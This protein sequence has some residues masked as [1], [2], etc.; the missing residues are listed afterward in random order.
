MYEAVTRGIRIRV[1]PQYLEDQSSPEESEFFWAYTIDIANESDETVQLLQ[2]MEQMQASFGRTVRAVLAA[3]AIVA[4]TAVAQAQR[5]PQR[6]IPIPA[7][8]Q[9]PGVTHLGMLF[10]PVTVD[11]IRLLLGHHWLPCF[12][13]D[14]KEARIL[15]TK[16]A[17]VR[18]QVID[19]CGPTF[20]GLVIFWKSFS[21]HAAHCTP[22]HWSF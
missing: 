5:Q 12:L 15:I 14:G 6:A 22:Q 8:D 2:F 19:E 3:A 4:S 13:C 17:L 9:M 11:I 21:R 1:T 20:G 18:H 7:P 16:A 10:R